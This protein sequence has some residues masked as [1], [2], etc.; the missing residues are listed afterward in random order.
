MPGK[1]AKGLDTVKH[2]DTT[3]LDAMQSDD[4]TPEVILD[5]ETG[6]PIGLRVG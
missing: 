4:E 1:R 5:P 2:I 3:V 6:E